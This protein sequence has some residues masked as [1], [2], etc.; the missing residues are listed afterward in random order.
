M[1]LRIK[2]SPACTAVFFIA[3][4]ICTSCVQ[5]GS[6]EEK[7]SEEKVLRAALVTG[8]DTGGSLDPSISWEGWPMRRAGI[9]ETLFSYDE[10]M[11]L[12]PELATGYKQLNDTGWEIQLRR[13]VSFHDGT[14]MD[15]DAVIYSINRVLDPS[16]SR[17]SEYSFIKNIYKTDDYTIVVET[18]ESY[19][20][21]IPMFT[22]TIMSIVSPEASD[23]DKEPVG[24]GPF[25]F[26]SF[27]PGASIEL[28]KNPDYWGEEP[29]IDRVI[30]QY[31]KDATA[32]TLLLKSGDVD[33]TREVLQSEYASL[34]ADPDINIVSRE[35]LRTYF[36]YVNEGKA[37]FD[38]VK[39]RQALNYA[40]DRQEIVDTA[41]EGVAG[42]PA[43]GIFPDIMPWS[44]N[45]RIEA[46]EYNPEKA[47]ELFSEAGITQGNDGRL[48]YNREP[49]TIEIQ[50]YT[51]QAAH[52]PMA[53]VI[54]A[55]L[56]K[57]G[58]TTTIK[59]A[60]TN[61]IIADATA[62]NYDLALYSWGVSPVGDPDYFVSSHFLSTGTYA[63]T[64][65]RYSNPQVDEWILEARAETDEEKRAELY[66][67]IQE[68]VQNDAVL[69]CVA[70]KKEIDGLS[71]D[72]KG[73]EIYPNEYTFITNE[74]EI[75]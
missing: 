33:I 18:N 37:P 24:T 1:T 70:Y 60:E 66:D 8:P 20:P 67:M 16:N 26:V 52:Q 54:A 61:S 21:A 69:V 53:E 72:L 34:E 5:T 49:F 2:L 57:I 29:K 27:E 3:V 75:S 36:M 30:I 25:M 12:Q 23:L 40:L 74:M 38:D 56:E 31:S 59:I 47:L 45:D 13:N 64:W 39:V 11:N 32:R 51:K 46:Y 6:S 71:P 73:F 22:D 14:K 41:L 65:L 7:V 62:G 17:S 55:Q 50:T 4:I 10:N 35:T 48:Y 68:Q 28:V 42:S 19:A 15:A 58:I 9:Y 44:A 63:S 43:I